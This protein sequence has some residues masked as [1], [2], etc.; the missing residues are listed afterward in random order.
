MKKKNDPINY[1]SH[2]TFG[3]IEVIEVIEDWE[4]DF[5]E[6]NTIKYIARAHHK[7]N[8]LQDLEKALWYLQRKITKIK[9]D[10]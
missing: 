9:D 8:Q 3:N 2:Y 1:P 5:H 4:L 6:G 10:E 7:G